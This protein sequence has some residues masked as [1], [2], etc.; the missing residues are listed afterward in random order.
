MVEKMYAVS[1]WVV[2]NLKFIQNYNLIIRTKTFSKP[3][4]PCI[5]TF[6]KYLHIEIT[7]IKL[8]INMKLYEI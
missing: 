1:N 4:Y 7:M 6:F 5:F 3:L 2:A 8:Q